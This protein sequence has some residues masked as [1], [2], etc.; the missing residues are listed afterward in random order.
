MAKRTVRFRA[1]AAADVD[2][3][4]DHYRREAG[5]A[6]ALDVVDALEQGVRRIRRPHLGSLRFSYELDVPELRA[7]ATQRFPY[8]V[9][10]VPDDDNIDVWRVLHSRRDM[11]A[12]IADDP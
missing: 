2:A 5:E 6:V 3:A 9:F 8:L 1:R 12:T 4:V 11:P 7:I 10:Y